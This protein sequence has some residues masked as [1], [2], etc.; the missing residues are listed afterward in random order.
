MENAPVLAALNSGLSPV[1]TRPRIEETVGPG[2]SGWTTEAPAALRALLDPK[3]C[4]DQVLSISIA[5][6]DRMRRLTVLLDMALRAVV[7]RYGE[8]ERIRTIY[9]LPPELDDILRR[10]APRPYRVGWYRPDVIFDR[11]GTTRICEIGARYSMNGWMVS[12]ALSKGHA[13]FWADLCS[14]YTPGSTLALVHRREPGGEVDCLSDHLQRT[15]V[16]FLSVKPEEMELRDG[17]LTARGTVLDRLILQM[18]RTELLY[19][20]PAVL[21]RLMECGDYFNDVRTLILVH[22]KRVLAVLSDGAIMREAMPGNLYAELQPHL[23]PSFCIGSA[24]E[25]ERFLEQDGDWI[26]KQ[27]S[28]GRGIGTLVRSRCGADEWA[29]LIRGNWPSL[30]FQPYLD[31]LDYVEADTGLTIH[32]VGMLLCRD[33]VCYGNGVF[34][35]SDEAVINLHQQ[36]G[37]LYRCELVP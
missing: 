14:P 11:E 19:F 30:M 9:A 18:D 6:R 36:R 7:R 2:G 31:Q 22:D 15:G 26:A 10:A 4:A 35:G 20:Q 1:L 28:G 37:R 12:R 29:D 13:D 3:D 23:I 32:M 21:D 5:Y 16:H 17:R 33:D 24:A 25:V 34:R 8:D 27:N